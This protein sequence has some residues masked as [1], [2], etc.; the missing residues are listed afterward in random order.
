ML[1]FLPGRPRRNR[2]RVRAAVNGLALA[3]CL[4]AACAEQ[5]VSLRPGRPQ[6]A[7]DYQG[8]FERWT[9]HGRILDW[10]ELDT[11]LVV[12]ATL[13]APEFLDAFVARYLDAYQIA[14]PAEQ[15]R[16]AERERSRY[17]GPAFL[18]QVEA[19]NYNWADLSPLK[20]QWRIALVDASGAE[21]VAT[22]VDSVKTRQSIETSLYGVATAAALFAPDPSNPLSRSY[23]VAFPAERPGGQ[24]T[25]PKDA[26]SI[27]LR[28]AGPRGKTDLQWNFQ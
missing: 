7:R 17:P 2:P 13:R 5:P 26:R 12:H 21:T 19:H 3:L 24:P 28:I 25:L 20:A 4:G 1:D 23:Y 8:A 14:D 9:R 15:T 6:T 10:R 27:T 18:V 22:T 16:V 11:V